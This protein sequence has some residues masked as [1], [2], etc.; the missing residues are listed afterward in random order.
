MSFSLYSAYS[1]YRLIKINITKFNLLSL[2]N[3]VIH[4]L[5]I[6]VG[7][8]CMNPRI[9]WLRDKLKVQN[10]E[11]MIIKNCHNIKYLT[12][13]EAEGTL[14][15]TT[16]ENIFITDSRYIEEVNNA[17]TIDDEITVTDVRGYSRDDYENFFMFCE[18]VGFE[19]DSITYA[20]YRRIQELYKCNNL[21]ETEKIIEKLRSV[22]ECDE[23]ECIKK[24]CK[25]T[26][27]CFNYLLNYIKKGMTEKEIAHEIKEFFTKNGANDIAFEPIV[28]SGPNSSKPHAVPT[29]RKIQSNDVILID[30]GCKYNGY[31]SDMTRTIFVDS[32]NDNLKR[33]YEFVLDVQKQIL[34]MLKEGKSIRDIVLVFE[35]NYNVSR[36]VVM[37]ALGHG[38]GLECHELPILS[39]KNM[40]CLKENMVLAIEPGIYVAGN[41]GIRIEDTVLINKFAGETLTES[42]KDIVIIKG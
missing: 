31:S 27:D 1:L 11:G 37:H 41:Y 23:I 20:E 10:I 26:D 42:T 6:V 13:L 4:N 30:M 2:I 7:G 40:N 3:S 36:H 24:A 35:N 32:V 38:V 25:I 34:N 39:S 9:R 8:T 18:N 33:E 14:L 12:G 21:V 22:K 28:A 29:D 16:K 17:L 5:H 15:I 19:E